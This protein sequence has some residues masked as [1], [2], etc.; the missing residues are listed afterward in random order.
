MSDLRITAGRRLAADLNAIRK[1]RGI[2]VKDVMDATR[3]AENVVEE[4]EQTGLVSN[5]MFNRV[6]LRSLFRSYARAVGLEETRVLTALDEAL[7]G[8]YGGS[9]RPEASAQDRP[10]D[11]QDVL[12]PDLSEPDDTKADIT[13]PSNEESVT[14]PHPAGRLPHPAGRLPDPVGKAGGVVLLPNLRGMWMAV[15]AGLVLLSLVAAALIWVL[16]KTDSVEEVDDMKTGP[17]SIP[18]SVVSVERPA[19]VLPD[20]LQIGLTATVEPLD[21]IRI[22][23][24]VEQEIR[25]PSAAD[26]TLFFAV[27]PSVRFPLWLEQDS[28]IVFRFR[29]LAQFEREVEH[30]TFTINGRALPGEWVDDQG[31]YTVHRDSVLA[32]LIRQTGAATQ[33]PTP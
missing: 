28:T 18:D 33:R 32:W 12:E 6:Y 20:T 29:Q 22:I 8:A 25:I 30:A 16:S 5:P 1:E 4:L 15:V 7:A 21:P 13:A 2:S 10:M 26:T 27:D 14:L 19:P 17:V 11:E 31:V 24:D 9:L 23:L 3:L